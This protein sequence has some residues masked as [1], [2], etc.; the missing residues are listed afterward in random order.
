MGGIRKESRKMRTKMQY[1]NQGHMA[2]WEI[3]AGAKPSADEYLLMSKHQSLG[4]RN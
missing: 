4:I 2:F 1:E 3:K